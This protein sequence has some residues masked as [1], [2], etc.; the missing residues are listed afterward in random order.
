VL[1]PGGGLVIGFIDRESSLGRHYLA[2][3]AQ[4]VFYC[5]AKFHSADEVARLLREAGFGEPVWAQTLST[6][7]EETREVEALCAGCG[8]GAFVVVRAPA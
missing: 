2:H 1:R 8:R 7:L 5:G 3:Q 4:S 6:P